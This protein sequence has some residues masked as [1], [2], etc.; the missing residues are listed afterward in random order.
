MRNVL[1]QMM[2]FGTMFRVRGVDYSR[3]YDYLEAHP[4]RFWQHDLA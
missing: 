2:A 1:G 4:E 3:L